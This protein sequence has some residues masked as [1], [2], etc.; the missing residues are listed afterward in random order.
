[1][2]QAIEEKWARTQRQKEQNNKKMA[3]KRSVIERQTRSQQ[4]QRDKLRGKIEMQSE[5]YRTIQEDKVRM[6]AQ[7]QEMKKKAEKE[8]Q[9]IMQAFEKMKAKGKMDPKMLAKF[10]ISLD[11]DPQPEESPMYKAPGSARPP[12][13]QS[14]LTGSGR[15]DRSRAS[16]GSMPAKKQKSSMQ[17]EI[18]EIKK[19]SA[20]QAKKRIDDL[21]KKFSGELMLILEEEEKVERMREDQLRT[22]GNPQEAAELEE[23]FAKERT[24][25]SKRIIE[26]SKRHE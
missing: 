16:Q 23:R 1:M 15:M 2:R 20:I 17:E 9:E 7:R 18:A 11:E 21:R 25:A 12:K 4:A 6:Q 24:S 8:K 26:T 22:T 19:L 14:S 13:A 5:V 3:E 10:G